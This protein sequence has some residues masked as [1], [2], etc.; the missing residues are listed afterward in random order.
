M[1]CMGRED[2]RRLRRRSCCGHSLLQVLYSGRSERLLLE[3][4]NYNLLFRWFVGLE[5]DD[6]VWDVTVFTKNRE[7]LIV[8][9]VAQK[10]FAAVVEQ[11]GGAGWLSDEHFTVGGTLIEAWANRRSI[12]EKPEPPPG[13]R[14][15]RGRKLLRDTHASK[16]DPEARRFRR[17]RAAESRVELSGSRDHGKPEWAGG[18]GVRDAIQHESGT[19]SGRGHA[20][21]TQRR[22]A[23]DDAGSRPGGS[24]AGVFTKSKQMKT[25]GTGVR[26]D[27]TCGGIAADEVSRTAA[28]GVDVSTG[29]G[30]VE[31]ETIGTMARS[32]GV[33][34]K[35]E[36]LLRTERSV[37]RKEIQGFRP[38]EKRQPSGV[39]RK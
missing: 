25:R 15:A 34:G 29:S 36:S 14:G 10:F 22:K 8:G 26:L 7:R 1:R 28:G 5:M 27:E 6:E 39:G 16:R 21:A 30:S 13:G 18:G 35:G 20:A 38:A 3:E 11:A 31:P 37:E 32:S 19:G 17:S 9:A 33:R 4:R 24:G 2:G 12:V 23:A